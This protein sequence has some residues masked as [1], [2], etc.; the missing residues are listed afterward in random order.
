MLNF[1]R[2]ARRREI[3]FHEDDYCQQQ[4]LPLDAKAFANEEL[5]SIAEFSDTHRAPGGFG[6]TDMYMR[7]NSPL[8][9]RA[10]GISRRQFSEAVTRSLA[11]FDDVYTG[12]SSHRERCN[13]TA[14]WGQSPT[15]AL[16]ADWDEAEVI[17]NCWA[18]FFDQEEASI[19]AA[20]QAVASLSDIQPLIYVDWAWN[21]ACEASK[22]D[23]F[24][25]LLRTKLKTIEENIAAIKKG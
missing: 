12:Y 18:M 23:A 15:C 19:Q 17:T 1:F 13:R 20:A 25:D 3:Y 5:K 10:L 6:W 14:A 7:S 22:V 21:Y 9:L 24:S 2:R 8:E 11:P 4:I 16:L